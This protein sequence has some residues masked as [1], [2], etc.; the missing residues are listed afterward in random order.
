M[1]TKGLS[2]GRHWLTHYEV[3]STHSLAAVSPEL[4]LQFVFIPECP[5]V[6]E[7]AELAAPMRSSPLIRWLRVT[8]PMVLHTYQISHFMIYNQR[9]MFYTVLHKSLFKRTKSILYVFSRTWVHF[10]IPAS[11]A[12]PPWAR[13]DIPAIS[14]NS[15]DRSLNFSHCSHKEEISTKRK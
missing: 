5:K 2:P 4:S 12:D 15:A 13:L 14:T 6:P 9:L 10:T 7:L 8:W 1:A 11:A 3:L